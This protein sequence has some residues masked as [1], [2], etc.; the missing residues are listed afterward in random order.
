MARVQISAAWPSRI[1]R[2]YRGFLLEL[3]RTGTGNATPEG[4]IILWLF[5]LTDL[6]SQLGQVRYAATA[7][8]GSGVG[9]RITYLVPQP[10]SLPTL[11][12]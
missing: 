3:R 5:L 12:L 8:S 9:M 6:C 10:A 1:F 4:L 11:H 7:L 2:S